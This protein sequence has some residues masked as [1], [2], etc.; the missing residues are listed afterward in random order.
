M[1]EHPHRWT[2]CRRRHPRQLGFSLRRWYR[3]SRYRQR[4]VSNFPSRSR[5]R[6]FSDKQLSTATTVTI[7]VPSVTEPHKLVASVAQSKRSTRQILHRI[8]QKNVNRKVGRYRKSSLSIAYFSIDA[9]IVHIHIY[10]MV[11]RSLT[12]V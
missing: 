9:I 4:I 8:E 3:S 11:G 2:T 12:G 5:F 10:T 7:S 1:L 6:A